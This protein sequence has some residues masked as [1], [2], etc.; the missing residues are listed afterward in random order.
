MSK[1]PFELEDEF[2][3]KAANPEDDLPDPE[4]NGEEEPFDEEFH[5]Y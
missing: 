3:E 2:E 4:K 1:D 5:D